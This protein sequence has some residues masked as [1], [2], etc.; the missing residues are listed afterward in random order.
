MGMNASLGH[1]VERIGGSGFG[2]TLGLGS[3]LKGGVM[4]IGVLSIAQS[5]PGSTV[6][7]SPARNVAPQTGGAASTPGACL[8]GSDK[9]TLDSVQQCQP[10]DCTLEYVGTPLGILEFD[11]FN[12]ADHMGGHLIKV[13]FELESEERYQGC[14]ENLSGTICPNFF[15]RFDGSFDVTPLS[16]AG[17]PDPPKT[18]VDEAP[19]DIIPL[20]ASDGIGDC[21]G[22]Y[23]SFD[24]SRSTTAD[25]ILVDQPADL[26]AW[27]G[28]GKVEFA[29]E[30]TGFYTTDGC[31]NIYFNA[32]SEILIKA[33]VTYTYC[34]N[35][36]PYCEGTCDIAFVDEDDPI[37]VDIDVLDC[38]IDPE[39]DALDPTTLVV[40]DDPEHGTAMAI[41][42]ASH[43][44]GAYV[45]YIPTQPDYCGDDDFTFTV[46][47]EWGN[48]LTGVCRVPVEI[49][50]VN[51]PPVARGDKV[52]NPSQPDQ[53][54]EC[55]NRQNDG[56][57]INLPVCEN[58]DDPDGLNGCGLDINC[59]R[60]RLRPNSIVCD[61][62]VPAAEISVVPDGVGGFDVTFAD[63]TYCG[64]CRFEYRVSD[65]PN[66][67]ADDT[68]WLWSNW[69]EVCLEVWT[70]NNPPVADP[71]I[72]LCDGSGVQILEDGGPY[73]LPVAN[74]DS[75]PDMRPCGN[76]LDLGSIRIEVPPQHGTVVVPP[77]A[78]DGTV[79]YTPDP[80]YCGPD[81][82]VYRIWDTA[83]QAKYGD[84]YSDTALV[85]IEVCP[86][87]DEPV[88]V[89]DSRKTKVDEP[90]VIN[91]CL[92]DY[93]PD[94]TNGQTCGYPLDCTTVQ[95]VSPPTCAGAPGG[96][97]ADDSA[98]DGTIRFTPPPGYIGTCSFTYR[99]G[100]TNGRLSNE[101]TVTVDINP[102]CPT[103]NRRQP[104]S[105]V[106][107]PEFD[108]RGGMTTF[109]TI[110]NTSYENSIDA[111]FTYRGE[112]DCSPYSRIEKLTPND[113]LTLITDVHNP[114]QVRGYAYV[115]AECPD[116]NDPVAFNHLIGGLI[117]MDG[118]N[119]VAYSVNAV[120]FQGLGEGA[121]Q[122]YCNGFP[123]TDLDQDGLRDLDGIEY[124]M[125]P[126]SLMIPRFLA[127]GGT[128]DSDLILIDLSGG[129]HF[130]TTVDFLIFND[131][132]DL[133]STEYSFRCWEK[134]SLLDISNIFG[135]E[136][137]A[138]GTANDPE[139]ILGNP[140]QESGWFR[141]NGGSATSTNGTLIVDP[142]IYAVL[143]ERTNLEQ[144]AADL[145]FEDCG[146]D[147]GAL[148]PNSPNGDQD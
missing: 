83:D 104:G 39:G 115:T 44:S 17:L 52:F 29:V 61:P 117:V 109:L 67:P 46:A 40:L 123:L 18:T 120:S 58:D 96:A 141:V 112:E 55:Y 113:T 16:P 131:N 73:V 119:Y 143:I 66:P 36:G 12:P 48:P 99:V 70:E 116:G 59:E 84:T 5:V 127:Q 54:A 4:M 21:Q 69:A 105:L 49:L 6:Q 91:V 31:P 88:A 47:D 19:D 136:H 93:D 146:Q 53:V 82:F 57:P 92:N 142:A 107:F 100:D 98:Q 14:M 32:T 50:G 75:D 114:E 65:R 7:Q 11:Q 85:T 90:I 108:N 124:D 2:S 147:N 94:E 3:T 27:E 130:N 43:P 51:D 101:A 20:G 139:E 144:Q 87:N 35:L 68:G 125:A 97:I 137:L 24:V 78:A 111:R 42:D 15:W 33:T 38:V 140:N 128:I 132:E 102:S 64:E 145:P 8:P 81:S 74:N 34:T 9:V 56:S 62:P 133:F 79:E 71:D 77:L 76:G 86:V 25:P 28:T 13:E 148:L 126:D 106:L 41:V 122:G 80:D 26:A 95:V 60:V 89:D 1:W 45:V 30:T 37:G 23:E 10:S 138:N 118:V 129:K 63:P 121:G 134:P 135:Q 103:A 22:T 72:Y 110:T